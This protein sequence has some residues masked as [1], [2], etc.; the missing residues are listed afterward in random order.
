M[1][2]IPELKRKSAVALICLMP[3]AVILESTRVQLIIHIIG[4]V[5]KL[6][7]INFGIVM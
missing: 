3:H 2:L 6:Q 5:Q 1:D 4:L 7:I